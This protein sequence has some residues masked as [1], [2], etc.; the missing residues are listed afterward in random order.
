VADPVRILLVEDNPG[1]AR[2]LAETLRDATS[3][4]YV[5]DHVE[6]L[7][8]A[9]ARLGVRE[10]DIVLLDL[11][12]P[13]A[14]GLETVRLALEAAPGV[15]IIVL[16]GL[17]D[18]QVALQAVQAGA[19]DYLMKGQVD[20]ALLARS[21]RYA[22]ERHRLDLD[23]S[24]LLRE[25]NAARGRAEAAVRAR[26]DVLRVVSHD[27]GNYLMAIKINATVLMRSLPETPEMSG[28]RVRASDI[29]EQVQ[30]LERLRQDLL[31]A[32]SIEAGHLS[33]DLQPLAPLEL[34]EAARD[35]L[36]PLATQKSIDLILVV[37]DDLPT[38]HADRVRLLQT[39]G[40]LVGNAIKFTP[41]GGRIEIRGGMTADGEVRVDVVDSGPGIAPEVLPRVF[42]SFFLVREGNPHG[43]GLGLG[44]A[45]GIVEAHGGQIRVHSSLGH[46]CCFSFTLP[47]EAAK[48]GAGHGCS[49]AG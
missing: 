22:L 30:H 16:T 26:D 1:D 32:S 40:N 48:V 12:L 5:L 9:R 18:E 36:L 47:H 2:L 7:A 6:R 29:R 33:I 17:D 23:R 13:D 43:A 28:P 3:L 31:D 10:T 42:D 41:A 37:E 8:D 19:Q 34:L 15:P 38:I 24:R 44:I 11:S 27:L 14:H 21:I 49:D 4:V 46:G 35:H 20:S 45:K 39:L 25:E